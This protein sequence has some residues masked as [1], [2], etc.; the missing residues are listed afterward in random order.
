MR[1][2]MCS[3]T[4]SFTEPCSLKTS[5]Q[6]KLT[7]KWNL[8]WCHTMYLYQRFQF[9]YHLVTDHQFVLYFWEGIMGNIES[10]TSHWCCRCSES[11]FLQERFIVGPKHTRCAGFRPAGT[12]GSSS[13]APPAHLQQLQ[14]VPSSR[15]QYLRLPS[16]SQHSQSFRNSQPEIDLISSAAECWPHPGSRQRRQQRSGNKLPFALDTFT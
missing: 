4:H 7:F 5:L 15:H 10:T 8:T 3:V 9:K 11:I 1:V 14:L 16:A 6:S 2:Y 12:A 13:Q